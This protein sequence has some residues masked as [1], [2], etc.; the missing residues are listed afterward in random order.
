MAKAKLKLYPYVRLDGKGELKYI[1]AGSWR[2][3]DEVDA[4]SGN[5]TIGLPIMEV[6]IEYPDPDQM[7]AG[8]LAAVQDFRR[9][10][11]AEYAILMN[12]IQFLENNL[13]RL[14]APDV[15]DKGEGP[16]ATPV[17]ELSPDDDGDIPF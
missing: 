11:Q 5:M 8:A 15:L 4:I 2:V 10:K 3:D 9:K 14:E 1:G 13:M 16:A 6:E 12:A 17:T 7:R